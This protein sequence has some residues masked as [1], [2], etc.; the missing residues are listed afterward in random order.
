MPKA[1]QKLRTNLLLLFCFTIIGL[2]LFEL[3]GRVY[4]F[5]WSVLWPP[6]HASIPYLGKPR[7]KLPSS[8]PEI[9][10]RELRPNL[11]TRYKKVKFITNAQGLRDKEYPLNKPAD[12][13]RVAV[14]GDS[15]T[16]PAGVAI[17]DAYHSL[18][19]E[20]FNNEMGTTNIEFISFGVGGHS[21]N[22]YRYTLETKASLYQPDMVVL[23]IVYNDFTIYKKTVKQQNLP[24]SLFLYTMQRIFRPSSITK[25]QKASWKV[26]DLQGL[27]GSY[28]RE[29]YFRPNESYMT[30][31]F[32]K[33][34]QLT[35]ENHIPLVVVLLDYLQLNP[36]W[37]DF[38]KELSDDHDAH[39]VDATK[40]FKGH[41]PYDYMIYRADK[42]PNAKANRIFADVLYDY[43]KKEQ[44][45]PAS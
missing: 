12:T 14:I 31:H 13:F 27:D 38:W 28:P 15:H 26:V 21:M 1:K 37:V 5:G 41:N 32:E 20:R 42:H 39:F 40:A 6:N 11:Q 36:Q 18:L 35:N 7:I 16:M 9:Q 24:P 34:V 8:I 30:E 19:E 25:G 17:E 2:L 29:E 23:G 4:F 22:D 45:L 3:G 44:L 43:F 10:I 33:I